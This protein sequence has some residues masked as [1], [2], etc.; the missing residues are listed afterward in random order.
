MAYKPQFGP[1]TTA[2]AENRRKQMNPGYKLQ[3]IRDVTD[4]DVVLLMGH[5]APGSAYP[6]AHPPLQKPVS[7]SAPSAR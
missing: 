2:V 5:R 7:P 4:E 1:G 6:T 3:K